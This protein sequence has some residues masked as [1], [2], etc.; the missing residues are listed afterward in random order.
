MF[1]MWRQPEFL[2]DMNE[3]KEK[4]LSTEEYLYRIG[5]GM[6]PIGIVSAFLITKWI[7]PRLSG[8]AEC[9]FW[10]FWGIYCPGCGGTRSVIALMRGDF[11]LSAWYHPLVMYVVLMY[12]WFML[13]HT[14]EKLH[15]P[16]IKGMK[17]EVWIMYGMLVVLA[18]NF[19]LKNVL[20]FG[21]G[22]LM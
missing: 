18:L 3:K 2:I 16:L 5:W 7:V 6:L 4:I 20:K 15:V 22:I 21:F 9:L 14:L 11:L 19:I 1:R 13:S 12:A 10:K 8:T 17:F